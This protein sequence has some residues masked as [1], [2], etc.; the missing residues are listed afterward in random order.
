MLPSAG[1]D[2]ISKLMLQGSFFAAKNDNIQSVSLNNCF[3]KLDAKTGLSFSCD[4]VPLKL[5]NKAKCFYNL[6]IRI[7]QAYFQ[8]LLNLL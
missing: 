2:T 6:S 8:P 5:D 3:V 7:F 1:V 4:G